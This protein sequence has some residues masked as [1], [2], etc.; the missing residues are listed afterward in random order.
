MRIRTRSR[1]Q[2]GQ[3]KG[4]EPESTVQGSRK[5]AENRESDSPKLSI[6][7]LSHEKKK[8][9]LFKTA[10]TAVRRYAGSKYGSFT[11]G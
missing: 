7:L 3:Y 2:T 4:R 10:G 11:G 8:K 1:E 5:T 9:K 6:V